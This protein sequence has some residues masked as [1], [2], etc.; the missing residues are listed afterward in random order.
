[1]PHVT[2]IHGIANK[3]PKDKLLENWES[4]LAVGGLDLAANGVTTSMVY[5]ADV[6]YAEPESE[7]ADF[8]SVDEGLGLSETDEDL[9]WIA[10]LSEKEK[11]FVVNN[12]Y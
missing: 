12:S 3:P 9:A 1:M 5:W 11:E 6:M 10:G 8:E 2:F 7:A 4:E